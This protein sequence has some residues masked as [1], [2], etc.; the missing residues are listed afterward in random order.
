MFRLEAAKFDFRKRPV[1]TTATGYDVWEVTYPSP[2]ETAYAVNNTVHCEYFRPATEGQHPAVIVLHILGGDF[3][4]SRL[5]AR[6]LAQGGVAA[7]FRQIA[8]LRAASPRGRQGADG[9]GRP[10]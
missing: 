6:Q 3:D 8:L 7:L 9:V 4:L 5:F 10:A 2:V 1:K